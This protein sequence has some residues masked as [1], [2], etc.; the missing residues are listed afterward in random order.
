[1]LA[2]AHANIKFP[3]PGDF[4]SGTCEDFFAAI[5]IRRHTTEVGEVIEYYQND[6]LSIAAKKSP[7]VPLQKSP[8]VGNFTLA[9]ASASLKFPRTCVL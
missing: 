8:G 5:D 1:M 6:V 3:T 2:L 7:K 9:C 4:W